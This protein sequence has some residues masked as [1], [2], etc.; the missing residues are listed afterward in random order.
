MLRSAPPHAPAVLRVRVSLLP[1]AS[2]LF[3]SIRV[4]AGCGSFHEGVIKP[5]LNTVGDELFRQGRYTEANECF[6]K[7]LRNNPNNKQARNNYA[8]SLLRLGFW[9]E[10]LEHYQLALPAPIAMLN[11]ALMRMYQGDREPARKIL[12]ELIAQDPTNA[13]NHHDLACFHLLYGEWEEGWHEYE[14]RWLDEQASWRPDPSAEWDG[15]DIPSVLLLTEQGFG[16]DVMFLRYAEHVKPRRLLIAKDAWKGILGSC[17]FVDET[18]DTGTACAFATLMSLPRILKRYEPYWPG[19]YF[20]R[21]ADPMDFGPAF[22]VGICWRGSPTHRHDLWRSATARDFAPLASIPGVNLVSLQV[23]HEPTPFLCVTP[24]LASYSDTARALAGLDLV[25]TVDTSV[26]HLSAAMG[27]ETW[28]LISRIPDWRWSLVREDTPWY[29]TM[30]L[31]RQKKLMDWGEV[32]NRVVH[33]LQQKMREVQI[34]EG[35][36]SVQ[37][38]IGLLGDSVELL[39]SAKAYLLNSLP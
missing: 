37:H 25:I 32:I 17:P 3:V 28:T 9:D 38:A 39:D 5:S 10:A 22:H 18:P 20:P 19:P 6:R 12:H 30:R 7:F 1:L 29:P 8:A 24:T 34:V 13:S 35:A 11:V 15:R 36:S 4:P 33:G 31:F 2:R 23:P 16:D 26:A 21:P 27:V 14:W